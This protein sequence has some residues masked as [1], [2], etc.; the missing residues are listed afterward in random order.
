MMKLSPPIAIQNE[1]G[2]TIQFQGCVKQLNATASKLEPIPS[3]FR[4]VPDIT[5]HMTPHIL[6]E[7]IN[8]LHQEFLENS[9]NGKWTRNVFTLHLRSC[10]PVE[11]RSLSSAS[12]R[13]YEFAFHLNN[14][15]FRPPTNLGEMFV[16]HSP[17]WR[18]SSGCLGLIGSN[19][20]N[21]IFLSD[22]KTEDEDVFDL[23]KLWISVSKD[24]VENSGWLPQSEMVCHD[25]C[26]RHILLLSQNF[27]SIHTYTYTFYFLLLKACKE[28]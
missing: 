23:C 16:V 14:K 11:K 7:G 27:K 1:V 8:S 25:F 22:Q 2:D 9:R 4:D 5:K 17:S 19:D 20:I 18:Q 10:T 3:T 21:S 13:L 28:R 12:V 6:E 26:L 24:L 15:T